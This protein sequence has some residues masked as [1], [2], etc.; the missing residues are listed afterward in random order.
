MGI[1]RGTDD[2]TSPE[3]VQPT[4]CALLAPG[5]ERTASFTWSGLESYGPAWAGGCRAPELTLPQCEPSASI[6]Q[7]SQPGEQR[8]CQLCHPRATATSQKPAAGPDGSNTEQSTTDLRAC[9]KH[10]GLPSQPV[11]LFMP[12]L[13]ENLLKKPPPL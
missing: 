12:F 10:N 2:H 6:P 5:G 8:L 13:H 7:P 4:P 11:I 1:Q 9:V 3:E